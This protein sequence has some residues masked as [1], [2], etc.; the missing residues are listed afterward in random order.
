[1]NTPK[2]GKILVVDDDVDVLDAAKLY[3]KRHF[4]L[5]DTTPD[6]QTISDLLRNESYDV[7]LLDM[8]F[9]K[10]VS[11]GKEGFYWLDQIL[12]MDPSGVVVMITAYGD[13]ELAVKAIKEGANGFCGETLGK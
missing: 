5:V 12:N 10:D 4:A 1:M 13:V 3:L 6:P 9:T 7:I 2:Q 11:S 8:N